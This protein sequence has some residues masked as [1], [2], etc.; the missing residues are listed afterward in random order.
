[1]R[2]ALDCRS[3]FPGMG[4]IGRATAALARHLPA[5]LAAEDE[6]LL[7]LGEQQPDPDM[8]R[9]AS[10]GGAGVELVPTRAAMIDPVFEQLR[11]PALL[12]ELGADLVHTPC[13][14]TPIAAEAVARVA[15]VHDVVFRRHPELVDE[16]LRAYLDHWTGV[17]CRLADAVVTPSRFSREELAA[18]YGRAADAIEVVPNGVD[19]RFLALA[20]RPADRPPFLLYVGSLE[21]KKCVPALLRGF[22][23]LLEL[24]PGLPHHLVLAGGAGGQALDL[25]GPLAALGAARE[26]VRVLGYVPEDRLLALYAQASGFVYLSRY[27]GFGLPPLEAM[28][29]G[30]PTLVSDRSCLPEVVGDGALTVDPDD[31]EAVAGALRE[32]ILDQRLRE[33]LGQRGRARALELSWTA[34]ARE[35]VRVYEAAQR[36][37]GARRRGEAPSAGAPARWKVLTGGAA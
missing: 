24:A 2:I 28:A 18:V 1:M 10:P 17:S 25:A 11:L 21:Q 4:G 23:R 30:I 22:D 12:R 5:A 14:T 13:F 19:E 15:T 16:P 3:V 37:A 36:R 20:R 7:V 9:P 32:L 26:R 33:G 34:A 29:A 31:R 6:L 27:E 8:I 35:L